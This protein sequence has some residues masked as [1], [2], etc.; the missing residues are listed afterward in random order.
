MSHLMEGESPHRACAPET[1]TKDWAELTI[2]RLATQAV[3]HA[4]E[5][6]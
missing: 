1:E 5:T 6:T 3:S 2:P 4:L